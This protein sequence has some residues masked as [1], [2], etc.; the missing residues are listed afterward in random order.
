[1]TL[2][3]ATLLIRELPIISTK[4]ALGLGGI[5]YSK[6]GVL[7][8]SLRKRIAFTAVMSVC[9]ALIAFSPAYA[10]VFEG[11]IGYLSIGTSTTAVDSLVTIGGTLTSHLSLSVGSGGAPPVPAPHEVSVLPGAD[12]PPADI[13]ETTTTENTTAI[14]TAGALS[15]LFGYPVI[16]TIAV[17]L[18]GGSGYDIYA[19]EMMVWYSLTGFL[20]LVIVIGL[21][22]LVPGHQLISGLG[23]L[24]FTGLAVSV[25][26]YPLWAIAVAVMYL[27]GTL[28][29]ERN[30]MGG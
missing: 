26:I 28:A 27:L 29:A 7:H 1:M 14:P 24:A 2:I 8:L 22:I 5:M 21:L 13:P 25:H 15:G 20:L 12:I 6:S 19:T 4:Q 9:L 17:G 11:V 23:G 3:Q 18:G 30:T 16:H 10:T